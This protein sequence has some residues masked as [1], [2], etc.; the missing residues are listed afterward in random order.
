MSNR[1][2]EKSIE[3]AK[4]PAFSLE[5]VQPCGRTE[6][7]K[8]IELQ[9]GQHITCHYR[10][11]K[12]SRHFLGVQEV[13][14]E[15]F[16]GGGVPTTGTPPLH[17]VP[18]GVQVYFLG[19]TGGGKVTMV[20]PGVIGVDG[21][22]GTQGSF[23]VQAINVGG[24][25][26][27]QGSFGVQCFRWYWGYAAVVWGQVVGVDGAWGTQGLFGVQA[28]DVGGAGGTQGSFGVQWYEWCTGYTRAFGV[29]VGGSGGV[30]G[31]P[32]SFRV[33]VII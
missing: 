11:D 10:I 19:R 15:T 16:F 18:S 32:W 31:T 25:G 1:A 7:G 21:A 28:N 6:V 22:W 8:S 17:G 24:A 5:H 29:R 3:T 14:N 4:R 30:Q 26:G 27:T 2:A 9:N 23:G 12:Q 33:Q 13:S 20:V